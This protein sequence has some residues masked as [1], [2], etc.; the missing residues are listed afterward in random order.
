MSTPA[1]AGSVPSSGV[2]LGIFTI[3]MT[4]MGWT[5][6]P[7]F[8]K[9]FSADIDP[10]TA[11]GWRYAFSALIWMPALIWAWRKGRLPKG[12]WV[13]ALVP[14]LFN[15]LGQHW[16]GIAPYKI[17]PGLMTFALRVH[18]VFVTVGA[19]LL[20]AAERRVI[21]TPAYLGGLAMVMGGTMLTLLLKP[22]E[23]GQ[24]TREGVLLSIG[25]GAS[26]AAYAL[27]VRKLMVGMN[28]LLAFAAV[29]QYTAVALV[30]VMLVVGKDHGAGALQLP[31]WK[32]GLLVLS[33][34][35]GIG[36][37]HT[38]YFLAI[39]RLG[40]A[41]ANGVVQL[42]PVTVS[43]ASLFL[44]DE[45]L[46]GGQWAAG[47][48]AVAGAGVILWAQTR[49]S[50]ADARSARAARAAHDSQAALDAGA[51]PPPVLAQAGPPPAVRS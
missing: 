32:F 10:Y 26:Y 23:F 38:F 44:F 25:A 40:L 34:V 14:A 37:G 15:T 3:L 51:A 31:G 49:L 8:L 41:V 48:M 21:K 13:A 33:S 27:S 2:G 5:S 43:I 20:F 35:I 18:V 9:F 45:R 50:A 4:L 29:S 42:Q 7:L 17:D 24:A 19:A 46:T 11:N 47:L 22:G 1:P 12:V 16:F 28:P 36:M 6:I 39:Q 30:V